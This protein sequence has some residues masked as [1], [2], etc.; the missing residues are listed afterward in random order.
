M[1]NSGRGDIVPVVVHLQA[2]RLV[3]PGMPAVP[4]EAAKQ[5]LVHLRKVIAHFRD[6]TD[7]A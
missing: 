3:A 4:E 7:P 2:A 1:L 6:E 5:L